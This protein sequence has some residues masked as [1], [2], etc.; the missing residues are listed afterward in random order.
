MFSK[1]RGSNLL[2]LAT[3]RAIRELSHHPIDSEKYVR[4]LD[5][6]VKLHK[7][8]EDEKPSSVSMDNLIIV[9]ANLLGILMVIHHEKV[10]IV[11]SR[12]I[13]LLLKPR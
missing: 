7:M 2:E 6:L 13:S 8:K 12:A 4:T 10:Q 9:G 3:N 5:S 1:R 11:T